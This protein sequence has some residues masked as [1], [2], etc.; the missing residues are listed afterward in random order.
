MGDALWII[1]A[2]V[3]NDTLHAKMSPIAMI[4]Y[5]LRFLHVKRNIYV[6][7]ALVSLHSSRCVSIIEASR[8]LA[9]A[10]EVPRRR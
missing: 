6:Q 5:H 2:F 4:Q 10:V 8:R 9:L 3:L 1:F 7:P